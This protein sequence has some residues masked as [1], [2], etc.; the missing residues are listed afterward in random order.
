MILGDRRFVS[1]KTR[2]SVFSF[3][4]D[5]WVPLNTLICQLIKNTIWLK[6][7]LIHQK[8]KITQCFT[9]AKARC[10]NRVYGV[11]G[12]GRSDPCS[13]HPPPSP[14]PPPTLVLQNVVIHV[15]NI[16]IHNEKA[17]VSLELHCTYLTFFVDSYI[18]Q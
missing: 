15:R 7:V 14:P 13:P 1:C 16:I 11:W 10:E 9:A 5:D 12:M 17:D 2:Y 4:I 8:R 18:S 3:F 6:T